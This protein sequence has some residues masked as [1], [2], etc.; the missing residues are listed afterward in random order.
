MIKKIIIGIAAFLVI[1]IVIVAIQDQSS[2]PTEEFSASDLVAIQNYTNN[3][4]DKLDMLYAKFEE[5]E[6]QARKISDESQAPYDMAIGYMAEV[7]KTADE[8]AALN[9]PPGAGEIHDITLNKL[10]NLQEGLNKIASKGPSDVSLTDP[11]EFY[12]AYLD[13][14]LEIPQLKQEI[15]A[16]AQ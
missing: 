15:L 13:V 11:G 14:L 16:M 4:V 12:T 8:I 2:S 6:S 7:R 1:I 5:H 3:I 9:V 10:H